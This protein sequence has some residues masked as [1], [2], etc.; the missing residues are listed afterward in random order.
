VKINSKKHLPLKQTMYTRRTDYR[1]DF[2]AGITIIC[3]LKKC[4]FIFMC[5][6]NLELVNFV[7]LTLK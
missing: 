1:L 5:S 3:E 2:I 6:S 4:T 7:T